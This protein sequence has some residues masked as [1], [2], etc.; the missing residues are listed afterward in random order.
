M[1]KTRI[2][3][4]TTIGLFIF[5]ALIV[6]IKMVHILR[7]EEASEQRKTVLCVKINDKENGTMVVNE[8]SFDD[9]G[10]DLISYN[11][12][13]QTFLY[14]NQK[15]HII[16]RDI[17]EEIIY[18]AVMLKYNNM[19]NLQYTPEENKI[20]FIF[21][22][23]L[24]HFDCI[25]GQSYKLIEG[26]VGIAWCNTYWLQSAEEIYF[27]DYNEKQQQRNLY[28]QDGQ[29]KR[30]I[31]KKGIES[32]CASSDG[33]R[34]YCIQSYTVP[35]ILGFKTKYRIIE[36]DLLNDRN[37]ILQEISSDNFILKD[38]DNKYL[39]YVEESH[40]SER[41]KVFQLD[42]ENCKTKCIYRTNK[43]V[44]GIIS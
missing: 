41:T 29:Q 36:I 11:A 13:K 25:K 28:F 39:L 17:N 4:G 37:R 18:N 38:V 40:E 35:T 5:I 12:D 10:E 33:T 43:K 26:C 3:I 1:S 20:S 44:I 9:C 42:L 2:L 22:H 7:A 6:G 34:L 24:Y 32:F 21:D 16:G 30:R 27:I 8:M 15:R 14:I 19:H 31:V 23:D